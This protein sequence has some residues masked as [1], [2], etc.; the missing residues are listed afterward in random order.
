MCVAVVFAAP[1]VSS[2]EID[3]LIQ[4]FDTDGWEDLATPQKA[5]VRL[6][7]M[8]PKAVPALMEALSHENDRV[9]TWCEAA[10]M[11][12]AQ[13]GPQRS[14]EVTD[15]LLD[16]LHR[17]MRD[18]EASLNQ[19]QV[20]V[21]LL[22]RLGGGRATGM[23][24]DG[25]NDE[26]IGDYVVFFLAEKG[27]Q[28]VPYLQKALGSGSAKAQAEAAKA[29][30][31]TGDASAIAPL[32]TAFASAEPALKVTILQGMM[33]IGGDEALASLREALKDDDASVRSQ[34]AR[35]VGQLGGL[36]E[37]ALLE[38]IL[39]DSEAVRTAAADGLIMLGDRHREKGDDEGATRAYFSAYNAVFNQDQ[40][41]ALAQR[42]RG[43]GESVDVSEKFGS[44][45]DWWVI[46]PF[47]NADGKGFDTIY[48]PEKE[49]VLTKTYESMGREIGWR[50]HHTES[51]IGMVDATKL[52]DPNT[53]VTLYALALMESPE[54]MD[55]QI[56][57]GSD[58]TLSI[59]LNGKRVHHH[60]VSRG[61]TFDED[62][63]DAHLQKGTNSLLLK[64]C[65]GGG[66]WGFVVRI[67]DKN[68]KPIPTLKILS[69]QP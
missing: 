21:R 33:K 23:L 31:R 5:R 65:Q 45:Y 19:R 17:I 48:P 1:A 18:G 58:D 30:G 28:A 9:R 8:G 69:E 66:G 49:T 24:A 20:A 29:L 22:A 67:V 59:W 34:A 56:R 54:E 10:L 42:L 40:V 52:M 51:V 61:V 53:N 35:G 60:D 13:E 4:A 32:W 16:D 7:E 36:P 41:T 11:Q 25:V 2:Q 12:I 50:K 14:Q 37:I 47:D 27:S 55:V 46:G 39:G 43:L 57:A 38:Q 63:V 15:G 64:V 26:M 68:G 6:V 62:K 44:I 3:A